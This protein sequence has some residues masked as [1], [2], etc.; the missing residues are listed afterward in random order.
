MNRPEGEA[1]QRTSNVVDLETAPEAELEGRGGLIEEEPSK[2]RLRPRRGI[3][4]W[5]SIVWI[6]LIVLAAVIAWV[7]YLSGAVRSILPL[8]DP[9]ATDVAAR[10]A[11]PFE[12]GYILG[13][14][15]LGRDILSR[16]VYGARVSLVISVASVAVG[17]A[18]G[19]T[20]GLVSGYLRGMIEG[21]VV[22]MVNIILAF[23]PLILLL[24]LAFV[25]GQ[26]LM[27]L[28]LIIAFFSIPIYTRVA[29]ATT[30][31]VSQRE[32]VH[33]AKAMG[34]KTPRILFREIAPNV[35]LPVLA[36][37]LVAVAAI[38]VL[39]GALAF[40]GLSVNRPTAT[41]G[42]MINEGR[43]HLGTTAHLA[44]IPSAV[45]FLT[46]LSINFIGDSLRR[47]FD[48]KEANI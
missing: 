41:W 8:A 42:T 43:R 23:P 36:F 26:S 39:E 18:V 34:A 1:G 38:I 35:V 24:A 16:I 22:Q 21:G 32:F 31:S 20:L 2:R 46:V 48:V 25:F 12:D 6:T 33:A 11:R 13:S 4:F 37:G 19:G 27:V 47:R 40:L 28:T 45:M 10:L 3:A 7:A 15:G 29:R 9:N 30:L 5:L 14:D 17:M 44:F